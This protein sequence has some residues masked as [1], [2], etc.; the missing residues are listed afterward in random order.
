[1][2]DCQFCQIIA[3]QRKASIIYEDPRV[4]AFRDINPQAPIH[5][6]IVPTKHISSLNEIEPDDHE[7]LGYL[8]DVARS[9]AKREGIDEEGYRL[10]LNCQQ[11]AGQSIFHL[12][13][14]LLGGRRMG[15][16]PG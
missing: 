11:K 12:H 13:L 5:I 9:I 2:T 15:W 6:L 1:M 4:V 7:L 10:V 16:P 14:H 3:K 8:L